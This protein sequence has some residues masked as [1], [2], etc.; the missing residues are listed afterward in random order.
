MLGMYGSGAERAWPMV[1]IMFQPLS[2]GEEIHLSRP[3]IFLG[4]ILCAVGWFLC[5][6]TLIAPESW[7]DRTELPIIRRVVAAAGVIGFAFGAYQSAL[8]WLRKR[9]L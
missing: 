8:P 9:R 5:L 1:T 2:E 7:L 6:V 3:P 4:L